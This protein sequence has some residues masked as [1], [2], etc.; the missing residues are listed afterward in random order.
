L[1]E[2]VL[3]DDQDGGELAIDGEDA[4]M[5]GREA[6]G[7]KSIPSW[8]EAIGMIVEINLSTRSDRRRSSAPSQSRGSGGSRGG[9]ARGGRRRRKP[10]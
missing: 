10:S 5:G 8:E 3:D 1:E 4:E 2:I 7:H 9:R 6:A